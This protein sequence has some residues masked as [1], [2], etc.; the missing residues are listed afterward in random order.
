MVGFEGFKLMRYACIYKLVSVLNLKELESIFRGGKEN[1]RYQPTTKRLL[2]YRLFILPSL[3]F[4]SF[5]L[6]RNIKVVNLMCIQN[7]FKNIVNYWQI[8]RINN[9]KIYRVCMHRF[10]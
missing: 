8:K 3:I 1:L 10:S 7:Q 2:L 6:S 5:F 4:F 9:N